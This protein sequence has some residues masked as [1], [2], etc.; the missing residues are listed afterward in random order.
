[1][2]LVESSRCLKQPTTITMIITLAIITAILSMLHYTGWIN[3]IVYLIELPLEVYV[4][5]LISLV[6]TRILVSLYRLYPTVKR[7]INSLLMVTSRVDTLSAKIDKL[8][9]GPFGNKGQTRK[10]STS[11]RVL[12]GGS[13]PLSNLVG[14]SL[15]KGPTIEKVPAKIKGVFV[16]QLSRFKYVIKNNVNAMASVKGGWPLLRMVISLLPLVGLH[17]TPARVRGLYCFLKF[18]SKRVYHNGPKGACLTLKVMSVILQQSLGGMV[19]PDMTE[20]KVRVSRTRGGL[21]R[22]IPVNHREA[23]RRG[24]TSLARFYL[25]LFSIY[26]LMTFD[27]NYDMNALTKTIITPVEKLIPFTHIMGELTTFIPLFWRML[28]REIG[29]NAASLGVELRRMYEELTLTPLLKSSPSTASIKLEDDRKV[30]ELS[31]LE[32]M[33]ESDMTPTV[34][35][36]PLSVVTSG[37]RLAQNPELGPNIMFFLDLLPDKHPVRLLWLHCKSINLDWAHVPNKTLTLGKLSLKQEAAGKVRVFAMVDP[38]TQWLLKPL[39][40]VIFDFILNG[41]DQ[42]GTMDQI[43]PI[44]NLLKLGARYLASFDLSAAT[45]RLSVLLQERLLVP[46]VGPEFARNWR[47]LLVDRDYSITVPR[48]FSGGVKQKSVRYAV[49]QP[50]GALSSW[51]MLALTHHFIVQ[52]CAYIERVMPLHSNGVPIWFTGY[53]ILGDDIVISDKRVANRYKL[54]MASLGVK[55]GLAKSLVSPYGTALE[56][57]KR[58]FWNGVDVS[59]ISFVEIQMA[60]THPAGAVDFI[61]KYGLS[62]AAFLKAAGYRFNVLGQLNKPIGKLNSKVRLLVLA[63]NTPVTVD[64]IN[65]FFTLGMPRS[66]IGLNETKEMIDLLVSKELVRMK[67]ALNELRHRLYTLELDVLRAKYIAEKLD[68]LQDR[69]FVRYPF[70]FMYAL[71]KDIM[72]MT[73]SHAKS[74]ALVQTEFISGQLTATML[75]RYDLTLAQLFESLIGLQKDVA[76][77]P[78]NS[79]SYVRVLEGS[80]RAL[81]DTVYIRL[82]KSLS[83]YLQ[84]TKSLPNRTMFGIGF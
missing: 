6:L 29:M 25:S 3:L 2:W 73:N 26:R 18:L 71:V 66:G 20:L 63:L 58:T 51:A 43:K 64:E 17:T 79:L 11:N 19:I 67:R 10:F 61:K 16:K 30:S 48:Q 81:T 35:S 83:G 41:L 32:L 46:L 13:K 50:M 42:D 80:E 27:G 60:F 38:W 84:G 22:V 82:W 44:R 74:A 33:E 14:G 12:A 47:Q 59:P 23:I 77:L 24:D 62:L 28:G 4:G 49:G 75:H 34:S 55:I 52:Y 45:D 76:N 21:P 7:I 9:S 1:M 8:Q 56:F 40:T 68:S 53:A 5:L 36:H 57:A 70:K 78:I 54:V 72:F 31:P 37:V 15:M 39:H 65:D 69:N